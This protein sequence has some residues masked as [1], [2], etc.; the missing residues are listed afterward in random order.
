MA[1]FLH[2]FQ[3]ISKD[4]RQSPGATRSQQSIIA[5]QETVAPANF[6]A[7]QMCCI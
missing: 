1:A 4:H 5:G 6:G 7:R 2:V 3:G